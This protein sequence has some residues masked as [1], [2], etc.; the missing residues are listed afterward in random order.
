MRK[1][2]V[3]MALMI[4]V[5]ISF[6][7][8]KEINQLTVYMDSLYAQEKFMGATSIL[9]KGKPVYQKS[10]GY[11]NVASEKAFNKKSKFGIGSISKSITAVLVMKAVEEKRLSLEDKLSKYFPTVKNAEDISIR[12]LLQ[13]RSGIYN[14]T[15]DPKFGSY[16]LEPITKEQWIQKISEKNSFLKPGVKYQYS[17]TNYILLSFILEEVYGKKFATILKEQILKPMKLEKGFYFSEEEA[18][19]KEL[20]ESYNWDIDSIWKVQPLTH[21]SIPLGAGAIQADVES[22]NR[23]FWKLMTNEL[24]QASSLEEMKRVEDNVGLGLYKDTIDA[25]TYWGHG[26]AID[27]FRSQALVSTESGWSI[28]VISNGVNTGVD[29][30]ANDMVLILSGKEVEMPKRAHQLD[31]SWKV[32]EYEGEYVSGQNPLKISLKVKRGYLVAQATGQSAF[33]LSPI[34]ALEYEFK[35]AGLKLRL[36]GEGDG[37][38]LEQAGRK[39]LFT[40]RK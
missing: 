23:F 39:T 35:A 9:Y 37:F 13:H 1:V 34:S 22:L 21:P 6:A 20:V 18:R 30:I 7:Q 40:R 12:Q 26:G 38:E 10:W 25:V 24:L 2:F 14:M 5:L 27:G 3:T 36:N 16:Y 4:L 19:N 28:V 17:N 29:K 11:A 33:I 32:E 15:N 8:S 31:A